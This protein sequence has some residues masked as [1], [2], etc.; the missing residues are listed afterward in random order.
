MV[1]YF[2]KNDS[3]H[4]RREPPKPLRRGY[5]HRGTD[6]SWAHFC[7]TRENGR[8]ACTPSSLLTSSG[9]L[10]ERH[11]MRKLL[12][13]TMSQHSAGAP[14]ESRAAL[15][16]S[17]KRLRDHLDLVRYKLRTLNRSLKSLRVQLAR[18]FI[19]VANVCEI[20]CAR[21]TALYLTES[22]YLALSGRHGPLLAAAN[23]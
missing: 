10:Y 4:C 2:Q 22:F 12:D 8:P 23:F 13:P 6:E 11:S 16:R 18:I 20:L 17:R 7:Q 1:C 5:V 9:G 15:N 21:I 14:K 3:R 19:D